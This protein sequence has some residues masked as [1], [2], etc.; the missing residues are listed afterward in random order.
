MSSEIVHISDLSQNVTELTDEAVQTSSQGNQAVRESMNQR[1]QI[2]DKTNRIALTVQELGSKSSEIE[3]IIWPLQRRS[4]V[5]QW[6]KS[7]LLP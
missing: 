7:P 6:S 2:E 3:N 1:K 4:R 5:R